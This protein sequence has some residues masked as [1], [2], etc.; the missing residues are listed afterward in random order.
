MLQR[1]QTVYMFASVIAILMMLISPLGTVAS[2]DAF[3]D[4]SFICGIEIIKTF[5][6]G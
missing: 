6:D 5:E 3:F 2:A 1:I 4:V